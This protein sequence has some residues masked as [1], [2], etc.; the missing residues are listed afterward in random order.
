MSDASSPSR[1]VD[2]F[3]FYEL[4]MQTQPIRAHGGAVVETLMH[5]R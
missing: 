1:L 3:S 2:N 4:H 5:Y